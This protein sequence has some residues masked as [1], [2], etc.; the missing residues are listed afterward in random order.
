M[1][2][3]AEDV[4]GC[5]FFPGYSELNVRANQ[6]AHHLISRNVGPEQIVALALPR[7]IDVVVAILAVAK[8]GAAYLPV[9]PDY[10]ADRI[11]Y[12]FHDARPTLL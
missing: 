12:L 4:A 2:A 11:A 7:T 8:T 3:A 1:Q 5:E 9:D 10:P 6:L